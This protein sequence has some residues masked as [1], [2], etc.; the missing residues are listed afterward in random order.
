MGGRL[1]EESLLGRGPA[2]VEASEQ[3]GCGDGRGGGGRRRIGR[4]ALADLLEVGSNLL[5][6]EE[7]TRWQVRD[8]RRRGREGRRVQCA[9]NPLG[10]RAERF[11]DGCASRGASGRRQRRA[12]RLRK[13]RPRR[14]LPPLL[15]RRLPIVLLL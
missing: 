10:P 7:G 2:Q 11:G 12:P 14:R 13:R 8:D 9:L 1:I 5:R 15:R 3:V 6:S 4:C